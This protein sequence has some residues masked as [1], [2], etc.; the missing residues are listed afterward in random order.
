MHQN[1]DLW[2]A[3]A[4]MDGPSWGAWPVGGAW[5]M[6]TR[7]EH[8]R[9]SGD[10]ADLRAIYPLLR[11]QTR[12]LLDILRPH[13]TLGWLVTAPSNSPENYPG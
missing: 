5:L 3:T 7:W 11:D 10:D 12:F 9:F 1:T 4:P 8:Y 13:P 2:R 6:T